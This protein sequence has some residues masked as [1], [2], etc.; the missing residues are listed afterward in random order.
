MSAGG[1]SGGPSR[2]EALLDAAGGDEELARELAE[3]FLEEIPRRL[4]ELRS[5][6]GAGDSLGL[7]AAAHTLKGSA[8]TL[9]FGDVAERARTIE[10][11]ARDGTLN[12]SDAR[13]EMERLTNVCEAA[14]RWT[15]EFLGG[16]S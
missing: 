12:P 13:E 11:R 16:A 2:R 7:Q 9:G 10:L 15:R 4:S 3:V 8:S 6:A 1:G 5:A 14:A